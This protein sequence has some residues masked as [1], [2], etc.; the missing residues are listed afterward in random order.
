MIYNLAENLPLSCYDSKKRVSRKVLPENS[1]AIDCFPFLPQLTI[2]IKIALKHL[3]SLSENWTFH[4]IPHTWNRENK[5]IEDIIDSESHI[6]SYKLYTVI[7]KPKVFFLQCYECGKGV[8]CMP[9]DLGAG[10]ALRAGDGV[11]VRIF[12][13][14]C[15]WQQ[16]SSVAH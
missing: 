16:H 8:R 10:C 2:T 15:R 11:L 7:I 12:F 4:Y 3:W 9:T 1:G 13:S 5:L 14:S 6:F